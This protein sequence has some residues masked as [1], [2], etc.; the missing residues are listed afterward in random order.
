MV[1]KQIAGV[2]RKTL[3]KV[4]RVGRYGGEE[5]TILLPATGLEKTS[6]AAERIRQQIEALRIQTE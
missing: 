3:R 2:L 6:P 1:L 5:F 4:D